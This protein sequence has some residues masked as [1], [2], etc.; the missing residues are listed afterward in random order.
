VGVDA[1]QWAI[2]EAKWN[3]R[4]LGLDGRVRR[5][6]LVGACVRLRQARRSSSGGTG[7]VLAW[8]VNELD[9]AARD[10]LLPVLLDLARDG[11]SVL[12]IEPLA[13][14]AAPWWNEW[15][16]TFGET[17]G[18]AEEWPAAIKFQPPFDELDREAGFRR[19]SL[20][21]RSLSIRGGPAPI[22][23]SER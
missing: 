16:A 13:R 19:E 15:V 22:R 11:A 21:A 6:D 20:S 12:V 2:D 8:A 1:H 5:G 17:R 10:R 9:D 4:M 14:H 23:S 7:I 3:G 18:V